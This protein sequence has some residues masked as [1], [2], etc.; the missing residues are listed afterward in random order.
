MK[1]RRYLFRIMALVMGLLVPISIEVVCRF[2]V[3]DLPSTDGYVEY[4]SQRPLFVLN[5]AQQVYEVADNRRAFFAS[6]SFS[7]MVTAKTKRI[8]VLGG[9]TVQGRPYSVPTS[10]P[11]CMQAGLKTAAEQYDWDVV[12][13]G[14]VSYASYRLL[15]ILD[16]VL[17]YDPAAIVLCAGHNEFLEF[18]TYRDAVQAIDTFGES[19][20]GWSNLATVRVL[21]SWVS[22]PDAAADVRQSQVTSKPLPTEVDAL[23]DQSDGWQLYHR[24]GLDRDRIHRQFRRN[25]QR[26]VTVCRERQVPLLL[27]SPVI[28]LRDCPP[29]KSEFDSSISKVEQEQFLLQLTDAAQAAATQPQQARLV[30]DRLCSQQPQYALAWYQMGRLLLDLGQPQ[31]ALSAFQRAC[32]EDVCPLR[33]TSG[34]RST[35]QEVAENSEVDFV[36][37]QLFLQAES[38]HG[39]VGD[40]KLVDHVHPSFASQ[41]KIGCLL[42]ERLM[43]MLEIQPTVSEWRQPTLDKLSSDFDTLDSLYFLRGRRALDNLNGWARGRAHGTDLNVPDE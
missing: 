43:Q 3:E 42:A 1:R 9:S 23:L 31:D 11:T 12:N 7:K 5:Q 14:G 24:D 25:I 35:L 15:P 21:R 34:L 13:C 36:D 16:E 18:M 4:L 10:F 17:S 29:F 8:F 22:E 6:D 20:V 37:L 39:I 26:M 40:D 27:V 19:A 30:M 28:N 2:F 33:M 32:N 38:R 41:R